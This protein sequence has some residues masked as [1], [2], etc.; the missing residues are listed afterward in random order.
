MS[1]T[2]S[3]GRESDSKDTQTTSV[4]RLRAKSDRVSALEG[5]S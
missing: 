5:R 2:A 1:D 4:G 3:E